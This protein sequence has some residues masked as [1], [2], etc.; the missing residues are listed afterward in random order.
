MI[1][2]SIMKVENIQTIS[3]FCF[4]YFQLMKNKFKE[5]FVKWKNKYHSNKLKVKKIKKKKKETM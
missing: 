4:T 1:F 2:I 5:I 3:A